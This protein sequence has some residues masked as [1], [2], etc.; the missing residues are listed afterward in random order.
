MRFKLDENL[1]IEVALLLEE[2]GHSA[3][4]VYSEGIQ[5]CPDAALAMH[6]QQEQRIL[7]TSDIDFSS[8]I[9]YPPGT[10]DGIIVFRLVNQS[11]ISI[12]E[13]TERLVKRIDSFGSGE[14]WIVEENKIRVRKN[15]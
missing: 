10:L 14:L 9:N 4:T 5:G 12:M 15:N 2:Y 6:C 7:L 13:T 11:K 8:I 3:E 1:P